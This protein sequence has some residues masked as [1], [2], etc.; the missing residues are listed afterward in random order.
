MKIINLIYNS[1]DKLENKNQTSLRE[2][3]ISSNFLINFFI[4]DQISHILNQVISRSK[5]D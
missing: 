5:S 2:T 4:E 3:Q 1:R